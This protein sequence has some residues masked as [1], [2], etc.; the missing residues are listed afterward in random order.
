VIVLCHSAR[1]EL[2]NRVTATLVEI[3]DQLRSA[4]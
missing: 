4:A 2:A 1:F 3:R